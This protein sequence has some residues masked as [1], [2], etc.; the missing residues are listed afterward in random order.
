MLARHGCR[1]LHTVSGTIHADSLAGQKPA[2]TVNRRGRPIR[3]RRNQT[4]VTVSP[5]RIRL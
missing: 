1:H 3:H 4:A 2:S 5:K